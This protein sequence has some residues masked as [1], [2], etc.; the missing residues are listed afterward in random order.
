MHSGHRARLVGK[1]KDGGTVYEHELLEILLFNAC[2]RRDLNATAHALISRFGSLAGVLA[3][4]CGALA[5]VDGVGKNMAEYIC[6]LNKALEKCGNTGSFAVLSNTAECKAFMATRAQSDKERVELLMLDKDGRVRRICTY[7]TDKREAANGE[8]RPILDYAE[9]LKCL[10]V[11]RPYG[12]FVTRTRVSGDSRPTDG[13][14]E[15]FNGVYRVC[16][17]CG[18]RFFDYCIGAPDGEIYSYR[19]ADRLAFGAQFG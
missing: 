17:M 6:C 7:E 3:A 12:L 19:V 5:S 10:S 1:I 15:L 4:D 2:P 14:D 9:I 8:K 13:D 11:Y 16:K 18:S